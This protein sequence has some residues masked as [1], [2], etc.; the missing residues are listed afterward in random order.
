LNA[1]VISGN[2]TSGILEK[3]VCRILQWQTT[4]TQMTYIA[5]NCLMCMSKLGLVSIFQLNV[6]A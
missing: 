5:W 2:S 4:P 6:N 3:A 1:A